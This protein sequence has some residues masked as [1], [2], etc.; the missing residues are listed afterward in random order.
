MK[1]FVLAAVMLFACTKATPS[2]PPTPDSSDAMGSLCSQA[3]AN[4]RSLH[5]SDGFGVDGGKSFESICTDA[6]T[7]S[8]ATFDMHVTCL[9][10]AKS[11]DD[12]KACHSVTCL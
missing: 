5:C 7:T 2:P 1:F 11:I 6:T 8:P 9:I 12:A 10:T 4:L 3:G